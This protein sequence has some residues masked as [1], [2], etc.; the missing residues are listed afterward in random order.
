MGAI[1]PK[2]IPLHHN[3][4]GSGPSLHPQWPRP[5]L[6]PRMAPPP[7]R[8]C[9]WSTFFTYVQLHPYSARVKTYVYLL[10]LCWVRINKKYDQCRPFRLAKSYVSSKLSNNVYTCI[11]LEPTPTKISRDRSMGPIHRVGR[12][13]SF[14]SSRQNWDSPNPSPAGECAPPPPQVLGGRVHSMAREGLGESQ[15]R[16]GVIHCGTVLFMFTYFVVSSN[17]PPPPP[18]PPVCFHQLA[19]Y[20]RYILGSPSSTSLCL[21]L[22]LHSL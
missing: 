16:R 6:R 3:G 4:P 11:R 2:G 15:F 18:V 14:F 21:G 20:L 1:N 19:R 10:Y 5:S 9:A 13:L 8:F 17:T 22:Y 7:T 12:V